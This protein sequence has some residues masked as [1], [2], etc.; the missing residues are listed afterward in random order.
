MTEL[1]REWILG[2]VAVSLLSS[3]ALSLA[4]EA[5]ARRVIRLMSAF[6]LLL[7][8][9][10]PLK[11]VD[12]K[13]FQASFAEYERLYERETA[14]VAASSDELL[15]ELTRETL[16]EYVETLAAAQDIPCTAQVDVTLRDGYALPLS[17]TV[18]ATAEIS[19][20][21]ADALRA[22]IAAAL[23]IDEVHVTGR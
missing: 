16:A 20:S 2:I 22:E 1:L 6:A 23:D 18:E 10:L 12:A 8:V 4:G 9:V 3:F 11:G 5:P 14:G 13:M 15:C 19:Q 21:D 7:A 17:C